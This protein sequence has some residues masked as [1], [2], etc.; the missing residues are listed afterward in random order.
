MQA[1]SWVFGSNASKKDV[2]CTLALRGTDSLSAVGSDV[3]GRYLKIIKKIIKKI[4][5]TSLC[6]RLL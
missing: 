5:E 3:H 6:R 1:G 4:M 2:G